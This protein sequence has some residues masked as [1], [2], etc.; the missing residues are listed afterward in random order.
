MNCAEKLLEQTVFFN[1]QKKDLSPILN[2]D[3][4]SMYRL[5]LEKVLQSYDTD[6]F[7]YEVSELTIYSECWRQQHG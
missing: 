3:I 4:K 6:R 2:L 7:V 5:Y 1:W